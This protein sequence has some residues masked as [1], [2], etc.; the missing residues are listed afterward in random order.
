MASEAR[1]EQP[2]SDQQ[3][4][5]GP[6]PRRDK[7]GDKWPTLSR[8]CTFWVGQRSYTQVLFSARIIARVDIFDASRANELNLQDCFPI[9]GPGVMRMSGRIHPQG[10]G[11]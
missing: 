9:F 11:L 8:V 4:D 2:R 1:F 3:Q 5:K 10:T 7:K 6:T